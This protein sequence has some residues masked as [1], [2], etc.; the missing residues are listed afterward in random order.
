M[1]DKTGRCNCGAVVFTVRNLATDFGACHCKMCQRWSGSALAAMTVPA[2]TITFTGI[3]NIASYASSEW[4]ERAWCSK[5]G[6]GIWYKV[7]ADGPHKGVLHMPVG[8]LDD[9]NDMALTSEIF[10]DRKM[11]GFAFAGDTKK[12][13]EA[14]VLAAFSAPNGE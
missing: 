7:T 13:T 3:E 8:L 11:A 10:I 4:A 12:L 14:E 9:T 2:S 5:C 6:C 1:V